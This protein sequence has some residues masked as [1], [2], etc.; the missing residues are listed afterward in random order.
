M[1]RKLIM[2]KGLPGS[3]KSTWAKQQ[4]SLDSV[5]AKTAAELTVAR[6]NKDDIRKRMG[7]PWS[8]KLEQEVV[9]ER[10]ALIH[11]AFNNGYTLVISDDTNFASR[12]ERKLREIA[13]FYG[14]EFEIKDFTDVPLEECIRR[15]AAREEPVGE[16]VIRRMHEQ[17]I[18]PMLE[19]YV[20]DE[21]LP[22]AII[23]DLD[24]TLALYTKEERGHYDHHLAA[25]DKVNV[26]VRKV[27]SVFA[28]QQACTIIY[29]TGRDNRYTQQTSDFLRLN[30]CPNG[31]LL[32]REHPDNRRDTV[33][34]LEMFNKHV[35]G[36][37]NVLFCLEDRDRVV[38]LWRDLGLAC[39]Q[40]NYES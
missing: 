24:G 29:L 31:M 19:P 37:Y 17:Y 11:R 10:D 2:C 27:I 5:K 25:S 28:Y 22:S 14:A 3:G 16:A 1:T 9:R 33:Y 38:K 4:V 7:Q 36:K 18:G 12:H 35:R 40:V 23:C 30:G 32:M 15:D 6:V 21:R 39:W 13:T 20:A 34:K 26:A 8:Q